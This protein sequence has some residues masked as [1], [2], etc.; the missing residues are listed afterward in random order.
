MDDLTKEHIRGLC[1]KIQN[2]L[3]SKQDREDYGTTIDEISL[4]NNEYSHKVIET[5]M[6]LAN[7]IVAR[8]FKE[9]N[10]CGLYRTHQ[11]P[12]PDKINAL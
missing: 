4:S 7:E 2:E 9:N 3:I 1:N 8:F 11:A 5:R 10:V 12:K 6:L